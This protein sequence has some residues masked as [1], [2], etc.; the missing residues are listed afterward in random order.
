M[1][2]AIVPFYGKFKL[3]PAAEFITGAR[4]ENKRYLPAAA[5]NSGD[6]D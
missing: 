6:N 1:D 5:C 4:G 3:L 2:G